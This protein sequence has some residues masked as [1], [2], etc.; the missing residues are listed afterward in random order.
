MKLGM[1]NFLQKKIFTSNIND[2]VS[3]LKKGGLAVFPTDTLYGILANAFDKN[4]VEYLY[5]IKQRKPEKPY[6]ILIKDLSSLEPFKV[7][8]SEK[9][10]KLLEYKGITVILD[11]N[12]KD[13]FN[14]LHRGINSLAFRIPKEG[15]ILQLLE[16]LNF[17]VVA[18]SVNPEGKPPARNIKEAYKYFK[19]SIDIYFDYGE[20]YN[21]KPSTIVKIQKDKPVIIREG[22]TSLEDIKKLL[23]KNRV[24][25]NNRV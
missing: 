11:I 2:I 23:N 24:S 6:L 25:N 1:E 9:E 16:K 18:P 3:V 7:V 21:K 5:K 19:N 20:I 8:I 10:K 17:P 13:K 22:S 4:S 15:I 12:E 14:Y